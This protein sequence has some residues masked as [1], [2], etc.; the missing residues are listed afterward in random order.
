MRIEHYCSQ[1]TYNVIKSLRTAA[2]LFNQSVYTGLRKKAWPYAFQDGLDRH[3]E[4]AS[5]RSLHIDERIG[6]GSDGHID[7]SDI[8]PAY[9]NK[10]AAFDFYHQPTLKQDLSDI[11]PR[12]SI[13]HQS[14]LGNKRDGLS[15]NG[16]PVEISE[17]QATPN[18]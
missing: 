2:Q 3:R 7:H 4:L 13:V 14:G 15:E 8:Q 11:F 12:E 18:V 10:K 9:Q 1:R 16:G 6:P 17:N 5:E